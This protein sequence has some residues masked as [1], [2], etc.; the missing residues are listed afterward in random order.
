[1]P[2]LISVHFPKGAGSSLRSV[3]DDA[4]GPECV[5]GDYSH[6]PIDPCG[7]INVHP[8]RYEST[9]PD[10][11]GPYAAVH[12]HFHVGRYDR[13]KNAARVVALREPVDNLISIYF[14]WDSLRRASATGHGVFQHF[15]ETN[16]SLLE[17]ATV[18]A[19]RYLAS[20]YY[21]RSVDMGC[22]DIIGDFKDLSKYVTSI[23]ALTGVILGPIPLSNV[24][25]QSE[26]R[27]MV[28]SD[29][30]T[31]AQLRS[32]LADDLKFYERHAPG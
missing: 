15:C 14:F 13:V 7:L 19:L 16:L 27:Q 11:L 10:S 30:C 8:E 18:P 1:M 28:M 29:S 2:L 22:F 9:K 20:G 23:S 6:D 21:S 12:G 25:L 4:F 31:L 3:Y 24:T 17:L 5:L 32:L 26:E